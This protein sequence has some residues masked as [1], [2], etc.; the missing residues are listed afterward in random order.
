MDL[1]TIEEDWL[2]HLSDYIN[3]PQDIPLIEDKPRVTEADLQRVNQRRIGRYTTYFDA[4]NVNRTTN[5]RL[6]ADAINNLVLN[7]GES[8]SFNQ[9]VGQRTAE[10]GYKPATVIVSGE[11][12]EGIGG[13]ICQTS[14]TLYNSV[15][16]AGLQVTARYSHS[17]EVTYVPSG[18]DATVSWGGPDFRFVNSLEKPIL[19]R[20]YVGDGFIT[21]SV[22]TTPDA[23]ASPRQVPPAPRYQAKEVEVDPDKPSDETPVN[24]SDQQGDQSGED[25]G[26]GDDSDNGGQNG[27]DPTGNDGGGSGAAGGDPSGTGSP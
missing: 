12:S 2:P 13:G 10:R 26:S 6:S 15:D 9:V 3:E 4:S 11:Y 22:Y 18:R 21:V 25:S 17:K 16:A 14:S 8:F 20:T 1:K 27:G 24:G 5:I 7:P 19:L 23:Q